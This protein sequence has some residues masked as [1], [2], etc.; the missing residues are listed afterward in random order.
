MNKDPCGLR[1]VCIQKMRDSSGLSAQC[2][3][4][5]AGWVFT[6]L[7]ALLAYHGT[8]CLRQTGVTHDSQEFLTSVTRAL[9]LIKVCTKLLYTESDSWSISFGIVYSFLQQLSWGNQDKE[10][11]FPQLIILQ[12]K[13]QGLKLELSTCKACTLH[14]NYKPSD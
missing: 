9:N 3:S 7:F 8:K 6:G 13:G 2:G 1:Y 10:R 12:W 4:D 5:R 11:S 14:L